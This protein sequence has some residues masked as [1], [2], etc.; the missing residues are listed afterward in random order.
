MLDG[1]GPSGSR[2]TGLL[3]LCT[4]GCCV[5]TWCA[6][7]VDL[8]L[9]SAALLVLHFWYYC[10][11]VHGTSR[12]ILYATIILFFHCHYSFIAI[13]TRRLPVACWRSA[14]S[15]LVKF[16]SA[17]LARLIS[18]AW[19]HLDSSLARRTFFIY[20]LEQ[21]TA[22]GAFFYLRRLPLCSLFPT[23]EEQGGRAV[24]PAYVLFC[25][26]KQYSLLTLKKSQLRKEERC[27]LNVCPLSFLRQSCNVDVSFF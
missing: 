14:F 13:G 3:F 2:D 12:I 6:I 11:G 23:R 10:H 18:C 24:H 5:E 9:T 16:C 7:A 17:V 1:G 27:Q 19:K 4:Y 8:L 15:S 21:R 26:S 25:L 20:L 22:I